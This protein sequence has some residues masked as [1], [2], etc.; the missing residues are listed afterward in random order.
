MSVEE[1]AV[2]LVEGG[3]RNRW[4]YRFGLLYTIDFGFWEGWMPRWLGLVFII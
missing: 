1:L 4:I 2:K 3:I